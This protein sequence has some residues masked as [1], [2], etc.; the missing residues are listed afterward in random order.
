MRQFENP[1]FVAALAVAGRVGADAVGGCLGWADPVGSPGS[2]VARRVEAGSYD[3]W[4]R[5]FGPGERGALPRPGEWLVLWYGSAGRVSAS[6]LSPGEGALLACCEGSLRPEGFERVL[7]DPE[8]VGFASPREA[9]AILAALASE[10]RDAV[11]VDR[12][13]R[14]AVRAAAPSRKS[15]ARNGSGGRGVAT[16]A[17]RGKVSPSPAPRREA[18]PV[19]PVRSAVVEA[20]IRPRR[21]GEPSRYVRGAGPGRGA[22]GGP[23]Q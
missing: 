2:W 11:P 22:P 7:A 21:T 1:D 8:S 20:V 18:P 13:P 19:D 4:A 9:R 5:L 17:R 16:P 10:A 12:V 14:G 6:V 23:N 3:A 15:P